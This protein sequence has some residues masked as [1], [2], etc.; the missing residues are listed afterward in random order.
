MRK[1]V[2]T[3]V[4]VGMLAIPQ[5]V[6]A[7]DEKFG[8]AEFAGHWTS[9]AGSDGVKNSLIVEPVL[10]GRVY[11]L[12]YLIEHNSGGEPR[13]VFEGVAHYPATKAETLSAYWADSNGDIFPISASLTQSTLKAS[14]GDSNKKGETE[15]VLLADGTLKITDRL[16]K[17]GAWT[18][19]SEKSYTRISNVAA[20]DH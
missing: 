11:R 18:I 20:T 9:L 5:F 7:A 19:F 17:D 16:L 10:G 13:T 2:S 15:Y 1:I 4:L 8:L 3:A 12:S 6:N 14:W